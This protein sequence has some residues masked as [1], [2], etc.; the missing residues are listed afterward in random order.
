MDALH[1]Y[2]SVTFSLRKTLGEPQLYTLCFKTSGRYADAGQ[3]ELSG[4]SQR[5]YELESGAENCDLRRR[6]WHA[7]VS[8]CSVIITTV[9]LS[10]WVNWWE[11]TPTMTQQCVWQ[12]W[13]IFPQ[14]WVFIHSNE[15]I[16]PS[17]LKV[18]WSQ[19][20]LSLKTAEVESHVMLFKFIFRFASLLTNLKLAFCD[21]KN[22]DVNT[23]QTYL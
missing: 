16:I 15:L 17:T 10:Q 23:S 18:L 3:I 13:V 4:P 5:V 11:L 19:H 1:L 22:K 12:G 20:H 2:Y 6:L 7:I 14:Q 8:F 21:E 9:V